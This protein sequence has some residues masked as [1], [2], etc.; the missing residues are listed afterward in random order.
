[1]VFYYLDIFDPD[2]EGLQNLKEYYMR[3]GLGD[4]V[5]K[6]RLFNI[7][8]ELIAPIRKRRQGFSKDMVYIQKVVEEGAERARTKVQQT[9]QKVRSAMHIDYFG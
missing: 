9:M 3:G 4:T 6:L 2:Q 8:E 7:L 5:I 1:M